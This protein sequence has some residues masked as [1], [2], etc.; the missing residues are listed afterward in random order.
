MQ[1]YEVWQPSFIPALPE[2]TRSQMSVIEPSPTSCAND[3]FVLPPPYAMLSAS[4]HGWA[5]AC[6]YLRVPVAMAASASVLQS[7]A[8][9]ASQS[10]SST[11]QVIATWHS[12]CAFALQKLV[13]SG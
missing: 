2:K 11:R 13:T 7:D 1:S 6:T 4:M 8:R 12:A 9:C 5:F 3:T 10:F